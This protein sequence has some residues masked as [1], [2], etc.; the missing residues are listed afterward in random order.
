[1]Q[2][3]RKFA[4]DPPGVRARRFAIRDSLQ[5]LQDQFHLE[6]DRLLSP[7]PMQAAAGALTKAL[8]ATRLRKAKQ[9]AADAIEKARV[10]A[11]R[12]KKEQ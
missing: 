7:D 8:A 6:Q 11:R 2:S 4:A 5:D 3:K 10:A 12:S 1:M 9:L